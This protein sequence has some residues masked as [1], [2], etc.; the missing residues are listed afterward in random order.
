[1]VATTAGTLVPRLTLSGPAGQ[2]LIQSDSGSIAQHLL[3][4]NYSIGVS[5][6]AGTGSYELTTDFVQTGPPFSPLPTGNFPIAVAV[7]DLNG[8]GIPDLVVV[9]QG[10]TIRGNADAQLSIFLG[11][12]D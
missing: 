12:G 7:A 5:A 9:N 11:I 6:Q 3:P 1:N 2:V 4:G 10:N 8:D